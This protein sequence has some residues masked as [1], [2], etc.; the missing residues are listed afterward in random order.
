MLPSQ[1]H[2]GFATDLLGISLVRYVVPLK[3]GAR[4]MTGD[5]HDYR[6]RHAG[7]AQVPNG[8]PAQIVEQQIR[9]PGPLTR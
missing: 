9:N 4:S 6:F 3:D 5:L 2:F 7:P 8:G 1:K